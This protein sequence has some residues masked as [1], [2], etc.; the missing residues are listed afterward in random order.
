[1]NLSN[2]KLL[3][4]KRPGKEMLSVS[5]DSGTENQQQCL[6]TNNNKQFDETFPQMKRDIETP[7]TT[8]KIVR[9]TKFI[10]KLEPK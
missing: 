7:I 6:L 3:R 1:M 2:R 4:I 8:A 5:R 10:L 9:N